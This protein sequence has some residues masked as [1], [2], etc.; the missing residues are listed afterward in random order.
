MKLTQQAAVSSIFT[1]KGKK[2]GIDDIKTAEF[3]R[4]L[5]EFLCR[6]NILNESGENG[7]SIR[8]WD[9][10]SWGSPWKLERV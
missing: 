2:A 5:K 3:F 8:S 6:R 9:V 10:E 7:S 4:V 1:E